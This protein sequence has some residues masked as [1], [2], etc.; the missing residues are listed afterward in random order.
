[1]TSAISKVHGREVLDSRG[2]PTVEVEIYLSDG[3]HGRAIVP[4]GASKGHREALELRDGDAKRFLGRGVLKAV[5]HVN[6]TI[7]GALKG[8]A[9]ADSTSLDRF[10]LD[11]DGTP[12][13]S[14]LGANTLLGVSLAYAHALA[15]S[16]KRPLYL[17]L[18]ELMGLSPS[19]MRLPVPQM[20]VLNGGLHANNGLEIQ[21]FMIVPHGFSSFS[22]ALRAGCEVFQHLKNTLSDRHLSTAVGDEGG[23][24]PALPSNESALDLICEAVGK[25][26]YGLGKQISVA[27]DAAASSFYSEK[28]GRYQIRGEAQE[29]LSKEELIRLYGRFLDKYPLVSIEDGLYEDDW[30][31]WK[32][33]TQAYSGKAQLVGDDIFVTQKKWVKQGIEKGIANAVLIKVNQVGTLTE[34][35][36]TM[37]LCRENKYRTV[38]SH[39]SGETEDVSIAHLAVGTGAGQIKTGS[40]SRSE[41]MAKYNELLRIEENARLSGKEIP[42]AKVF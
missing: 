24:A 25:A 27:L 3:S 19:D 34:T 8:R 40:A 18:N 23:F 20:N 14:N 33:L 39:R 42:F 1:M 35:F 5:A 38:V 10:L 6:S 32:S 26:G 12:Q 15:C 41:R 9:I 7:A 36:E 11:L 21:E 28:T 2:N 22:S 31:G 4:S 37:R 16:Q 13:K 17:L 29:S 30:E